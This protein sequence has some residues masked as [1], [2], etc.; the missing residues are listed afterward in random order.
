MKVFRYQALN[1]NPPRNQSQTP[2][3]KTTGIKV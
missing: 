2:G 3:Q 1:Q